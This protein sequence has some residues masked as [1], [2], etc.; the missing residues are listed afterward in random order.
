IIGNPPFLGGQ[1]QTGLLGTDYRNWL[2]R[3]D[4]HG[5]KGSADLVAFF[6]LRASRLLSGR[7]QLG[8]LATNTLV[9]GDTLEVGLLQATADGLVLRRGESSHKWPSRS[10]NL[11]IVTAWA[12]RAALGP[13][14]RCWLDG[15]D[16]PR[17]GPD[18]EPVGSVAGRPV[19]L[20]E[21]DSKAFVGSYVLGLGFTLE[22]ERAATMIERDPVYADVLQPYVI[23]RDLNQRPDCSASRWIVNF[24]DWSLDRCE[25]QY[26]EAL[27]IV[28]RFVKPDRDRNK[29]A[30]RSERWWRYAAHAPELYASVGPLDYIL[31][32]A[33]VG[34]T[35]VP[36]RV[37][38][39]PVYDVQC[40]VFA[41]D[42]FAHLAILSSSAHTVWVV[43]YASTLRTDI[44]YTP[45]D[46]FDTFPRP[47]P[48]DEL[49]ELGRVLDTERRDLML[50]RAWGLT[51][52]YNHVHDPAVTDLAVVRLRD[53]HAGIDRA[54]FD[55]Y[56]W[57]DLDPQV[58]HHPTKIGVRWTVSP[59]VR[60]EILDRL[61]AENHRRHSLESM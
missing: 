51:T 2:Q 27:D 38:T 45:S 32:V 21:N 55:A 42:A 61:L 53:I 48:T 8:Y 54:V 52:T 31:A 49:E 6:V 22:P 25:R 3:W 57:T 20:R 34:S 10:A 40:V 30:S 12:S 9:Q 46:V 33:R 15:E 11:E 7:G 39:G 4:A 19:R 17:I 5:V 43:R 59:E 47:S 26:P 16:V 56:G 36:V 14:G 35:L 13:D 41:F 29:M 1:K 37:P 23:G 24:R 44:R 50:S 28:R 58:G 18:L 60:F